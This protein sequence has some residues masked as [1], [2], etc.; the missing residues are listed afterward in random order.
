MRVNKK[1]IIV[2]CFL[3]ISVIILI[4]LK[5]KNK[6]VA[7]SPTET[8]IPTP[9]I[10]SPTYTAPSPS[11][12]PSCSLNNTIIGKL[13]IATNQYTIE[14]LP[15]PQKFLVMILQNPYEG[16]QIEAKKWFISQGIDPNSSCIFWSSIKGVAPKK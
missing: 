7:P 5:A 9:V 2:I 1:T 13:P 11:S 12:S 14:Y 15:A 10:A 16:Y 8:I 6:S 4:V 3:I